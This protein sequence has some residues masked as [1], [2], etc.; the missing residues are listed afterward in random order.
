MTN[1][2]PLPIGHVMFML[3]HAFWFSTLSAFHLGWRDLDIESWILR[4]QSEPF[5]NRECGILKFS[6]FRNPFDFEN[7]KIAA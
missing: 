5:A 4:L 6:F 1:S 7:V 3:K 2:L